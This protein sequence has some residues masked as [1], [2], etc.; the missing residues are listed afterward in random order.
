MYCN[1]TV[2]TYYIIANFFFSYSYIIVDITLYSLVRVTHVIQ[3]IKEN[4]RLY[5]KDKEI[6][7][8]LLKE[9]HKKNRFHDI[10]AC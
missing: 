3:E 2:Y 6:T 1:Y 4:A 7:Y 9:N 10:I 8:G 5:K